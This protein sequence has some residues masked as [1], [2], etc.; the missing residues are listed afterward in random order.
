MYRKWL[1]ATGDNVKQLHASPA[2]LSF[3]AKALCCRGKQRGNSS[4]LELL[5]GSGKWWEE[6]PSPFEGSIWKPPSCPPETRQRCTA[7]RGRIEAKSI[8]PREEIGKPL[9]TWISYQYKAEVC[10]CW[11]SDGRVSPVQKYTPLWDRVLLP[12]GWGGKEQECGEALLAKPSAP[13]RLR[14]RL[15]QEN[16]PLLSPGQE[17]STKAEALAVSTAGEGSGTG[18][19]N[20]SWGLHRDCWNLRMEKTHRRS[21][22]GARGLSPSRR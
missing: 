21:H 15:D 3:Q 10:C 1:D 8:F 5:I 12:W 13:P 18:K 6:T 9:G 14:S 7:S 16:N 11:Q 2:F 19:E 20:P 17:P 4:S 22:S